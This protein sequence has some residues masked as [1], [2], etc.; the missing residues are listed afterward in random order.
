[1]DS[2]DRVVIHYGK[3]RYGYIL[4]PHGFGQIMV[5]LTLATTENNQDVRETGLA[6][7]AG[8]QTKT[9][10]REGGVS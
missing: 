8:G 6:A 3:S 1:M 2:R 9:P 5:N 4:Q 10:R 7:A